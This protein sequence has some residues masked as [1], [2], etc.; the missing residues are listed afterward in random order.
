MLIAVA[1]S[2]GGRQVIVRKVGFIGLGLMGSR[3]AANVAR[4]GYPLTVY[5]R[6]ASKTDPLVAMGARRVESPRLVAQSS[7]VVIT[8][9]S[10]ASAV[11]AVVY[12]EDGLAAGAD[13]GLVVINMSTISP[14][15]THQIA[16]QLATHGVKMLDAPV[17]GSTGPAES[18]NLE[19]LVGGDEST[20]IACKDLL[21]TMGKSLYYLGPQGSG[22]QMKLSM[23]LMVA[24]QL[25]CLSEAMLLAAKAGIDLNIAGK[26]ISGSNI[27]SN[28]T[29]R[30]V[31][32][33]VEG[34]YQPAFSLENMHKDLG[35]I[36]QNAHVLGAPLP[37]SSVVHQLFTAA[38]ERGYA[39]QDSSAIYRVLAELAGLS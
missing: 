25:I 3:M 36:M 26:I 24:A 21:G 34:N 1:T 16:A 9:L 11:E 19:I 31:T 14:Q 13:E 38:K 2:N 20:F 5:N 23:N 8:M 7:D 12:G 4:A 33:I 30:K 17:M 37:A 15:E 28:L 29:I 10:E 35:L 32:N 27:A 18:G 39:D 6:T 22:A